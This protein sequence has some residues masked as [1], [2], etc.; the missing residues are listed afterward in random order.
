MKKG[1]ALAAGITGGILGAIS[2]NILKNKQQANVE[3]KIDKFK[4]YYN[5]LNQWLNLKQDGVALE[6][7]FKDRSFSNIAIYGMGEIGNR[8]WDELKDSDITV[9][10]GVDKSLDNAY[11]EM[12]MYTPEDK[13]PKADVIVVTAIF[14]FRN[15]EELLAENVDFPIISLEEV[16]YEI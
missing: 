11:A 7:Y 13:L 2:T 3:K 16:V 8:L 9:I 5:L 15:I 14:D 12:D 6:K 4:E 10:Y 1:R